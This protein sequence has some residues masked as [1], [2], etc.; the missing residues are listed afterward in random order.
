MLPQSTE[1]SLRGKAGV[2]G[3]SASPACMIYPSH[4]RQE[5]TMRN[6]DVSQSRTY[7]TEGTV[8]S[9]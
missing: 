6:V 8:R 7:K 1:R 9:L 3:G 4:T 5:H 2:G